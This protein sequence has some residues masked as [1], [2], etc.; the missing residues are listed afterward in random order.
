MKNNDVG[1]NPVRFALSLTEESFLLVG[2]KGTR[3]EWEECIR[4]V[5]NQIDRQVQQRV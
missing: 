2:M 4:C 5:L 1:L 3:E